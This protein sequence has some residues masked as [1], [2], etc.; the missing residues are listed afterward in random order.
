MKINIFSFRWNVK[1]VVECAQGWS[2]IFKC[3][4]C[5]K[6]KEKPS[7]TMHSKLGLSLPNL[8]HYTYR[9]WTI[10]VPNLV[11]K[12]FFIYTCTENYESKHRHVRVRKPAHE[13]L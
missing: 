11:H 6:E 2:L 10:N 1:K 12:L 4:Q 8:A 9:L 5:G 13:L 7:T 3:Q